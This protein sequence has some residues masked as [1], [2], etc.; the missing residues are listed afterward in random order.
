V[1]VVSVDFP[2][3]CIA[4]LQHGLEHAE[5]RLANDADNSGARLDRDFA[6]YKLSEAEYYLEAFLRSLRASAECNVS[7]ASLKKLSGFGFYLASN[8]VDVLIAAHDAEEAKR[9]E[10]AA[11]AAIA[12]VNSA[13]P[14]DDPFGLS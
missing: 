8:P 9:A 12:V 14:E 3:D 10:E 1:S 5:Q 2:P 13:Y 4:E 11:Q 7:A 6:R